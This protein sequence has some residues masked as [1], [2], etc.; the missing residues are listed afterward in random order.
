M[1]EIAMMMTM[2]IVMGRKAD[3]DDG[4]SG[5]GTSPAFL[6]HLQLPQNFQRRYF[7]I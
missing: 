5:D 7:R 1:M 4:T 2:V 6:Y 3:N